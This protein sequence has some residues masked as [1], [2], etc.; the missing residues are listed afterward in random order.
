MRQ[1]LH[2][3][4]TTVSHL[5][6]VILRHGFAYSVHYRLGWTNR[7]HSNRLPGCPLLSG[8]GCRL[9]E[10]TSYGGEAWYALSGTTARRRILN[11]TRYLAADLLT[12]SIVF[13]YGA[14]PG[15]RTA[16]FGGRSI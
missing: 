6:L 8:Y 5:V 10:T 12:Q 13:I 9:H 4:C 1:V 11:V 7:M 2:Y 16:D 15:L 14:V 3:H